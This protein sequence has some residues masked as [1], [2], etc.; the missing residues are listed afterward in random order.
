MRAHKIG[1]LYPMGADMPAT[2]EYARCLHWDH[3][4]LV[5]GF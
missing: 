2:E 5:S 3:S 1:C 4:C